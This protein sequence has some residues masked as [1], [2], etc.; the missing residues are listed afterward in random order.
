MQAAIARPRSGSSQKCVNVAP[1]HGHF[2]LEF[3]G[4]LDVSSLILS[5]IAARLR[6]LEAI[7]PIS[8]TTLPPMSATAIDSTRT[9]SRT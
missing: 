2:L 6:G 4:S 3:V 1:D 8:A 5:S 9:P 7:A